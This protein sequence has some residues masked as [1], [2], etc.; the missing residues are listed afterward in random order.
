MFRAA[1][2]GDRA[3]EAVVAREVDLIAR[4]LVPIVALLDPKLVVLGGGALG[5][6]AERLIA[7]VE[8]RLGELV[9]LPLP[10]FATSATGEDATVMGGVAQAVSIAWQRAYALS[11]E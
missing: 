8:Q 6:H 11:Q 9:P 3:A 7:P 10:G 4:S 1:Q 2:D 5:A